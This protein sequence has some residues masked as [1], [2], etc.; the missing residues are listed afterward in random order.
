MKTNMNF[1]TIG[2]NYTS[3]NQFFEN[4]NDDSNFGSSSTVVT[5]KQCS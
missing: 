4:P 5:P 2:E 3:D 1:H